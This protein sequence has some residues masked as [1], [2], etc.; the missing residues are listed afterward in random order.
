MM[1]NLT[2]IPEN[3]TGTQVN[4]SVTTQC[5]D[6]FCLNDDAYL[7]YLE[8][9]VYPEDWEWGFIVLY[10]ITFVVGL[11]GNVL[12]C[13]AVWRNRSM[14]TVTNIFIVNLAIADL[15]VIIICL[16]PTLLADV[17]ETWY[18]GFIMCK[19]ALF[20]QTTSVAVS[21]FTLSAISVERWYAICYPLHFKSTK[22]RA[23]IIILVIWIIAFLL[24]LPEIIFAELHRSVQR[25]YI[26][27][28]IS[29]RPSWPSMS[30]QVMYQGLM[31]VLMY[32]LPLILMTVTYS[33]IAVVLW[34]GRI[35]GAIESAHR[36][37]MDGNVNRAEEQ[38]ESRK[39]AA[40]MLITIVIGFAVCYFPVHLFNIL[41]YA[42][43][44]KVAPY[45]IQVMSMISHWLPYLNSS[46]NP[47]IYNFMS[48]KFRKE[49]TAACCCV[50]R[51]R[52]FSVQYK[53]GVSSFSCASQYT[54]RNNS[55]S[56]TEQVLLSTY[57]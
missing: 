36:P 21:V 8:D 20:L 45:S 51:R 47:V 4:S 6:V 41:R 48:A 1:E 15:T 24:A 27:L 49:F 5:E 29:C 57:R 14:R 2:N 33:M 16:P 11:S 39:K 42:Q 12:V 19:V 28:L 7:D 40:K 43:A 23:K 30:N 10:A 55:N 52:A 38:L 37:M 53:S 13:F 54:H 35:P 46:I 9:Y 17:T 26:D 32:L 34:T 50:K 56:C 25:Q 22:R 31:M 18:F 3:L 44:L